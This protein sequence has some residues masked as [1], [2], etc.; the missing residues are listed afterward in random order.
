MRATSYGSFAL[1]I[2]L[3][4]LLFSCMVPKAGAEEVLERIPVLA[5]QDDGTVKFKTVR[6]PVPPEP[7]AMYICVQ[8]FEAPAIACYAVNTQ[9]HTWERFDVTVE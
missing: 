4:L 7:L 5:T 9:A 1:G 2:A 8:E 3:S 6:L